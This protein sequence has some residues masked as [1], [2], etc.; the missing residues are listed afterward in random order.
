M[1]R[2][3][4]GRSGI[5]AVVLLTLLFCLI[6]AVY[7]SYSRAGFFDW[8][9]PSEKAKEAATVKPPSLPQTF[10]IKEI[11]PV[12]QG[13]VK[14]IFSENCD[15]KELGNLL[16]ILPP[17]KIWWDR[18][19]SIN[20]ETTIEGEFKAGQEYAV[21]LSDKAECKG[22]KYSK[23]I[24][25][26]RMPDLE[27]S[28]TFSEK[29]TVVERDGRQMV[30]AT[31]TNVDEL[32]FQGIRVPPLLV[33]WTIEEMKTSFS[34]E[35]FKDAV[36]KKYGPVKDLLGR[37]GEL[38]DFFA[39]IKY[40]SQ[41]FFPDKEHNKAVKIS[42]PLGFRE[43][44]E[45]GGIELISLKSGQN[46]R[47]A[48]PAVGLFRI[49]DLGISYKISED[50]LL[51]WITS[52]NTGLPV[53]EV[54]VL[55]FLKDS[56]IVPLGKTDENG[57]LLVKNNAVGNRI[58]LKEDKTDS[59]PVRIKDIIFVAA[60]SP[61]DS[62]F[63]ELKQKGTIKPD[64]ITQAKAPDEKIRLLKGHVFT[65]RGIYRPGEKVYFKGTVREYRDGKI[66]PPP[67]EKV[68]FTITDSKDEEVYGKE[69]ALSEFGT[70]NGFLETKAYFPLGTYTVNMQ[71]AK[72]TQQP[73]A[74]HREEFEGVYGEG[75]GPGRIKNKPANE[76]IATGTFEVQEFRAPRHFVEVSFKKEK[77]KDDSFV[78]LDMETEL[79]ICNISGSY[80]AGGP[81]KHGK[82]RWK[83]YF[84]NADF[85]KKEFPDFFFGAAEDGGK[86]LIESGES[87]LDE[88]GGLTVTLP[89]NKKISAGLHA[90]E[91]VATVLDFDGR[92]S[93]ETS[94]YQEEPEYM[95]GIGKHENNVKAGD[96]QIVKVIVTDKN[97]KK[98][99]NGSVD[100]SV[101]RKDYMYVRKRNED[102]SVYWDYKAVYRKQLSTAVKLENSIAVFDF[103]FVSGGDYVLQFSY[104]DKS[105]KE[106]SSSTAYDVYGYFYGYEYE[107]RELN[108]EKMSAASDKKEYSFG[109]TIKVYLNP[110]KKLSSILMTIEREGV[111]QYGTVNLSPGRKYIEIPVEKSFSPNIYISFLGIVPRGDFPSYTGQFDET[112]PGFLFGV[113][114]VEIKR[115]IDNLKL[116]VNKEDFKLKFEPGNE[117]T[118]RLSS[119]D[120][121]GKGVETEMA[122]CV[123]DESVLALTGFK[124]PSLEALLKFISPLSV[125][126]GELRSELLK[127]TPYRFIRNERLTG[128]DGGGM[129]ISASKLRKDFRPVAFFDP[130]VKT[131]ENGRA[132]VKFT[133]PDTM[134]T[135]RVYVVACDKGGRFAS[136]KRDLLVVKDFYLEPGTPRFFTK[137]DR[138]RFFVSAFNKTDRSG[139]GRFRLEK[140]ASVNIGTEDEYFRMKGF[141]GALLSVRG[142]AMKPGVSTLVFAGDFKDRKDIVEIK[143][144]VKSGFLSWNDVVFGTMKG[145]AKIAYKFPD[146]AGRIKWSELNP[147]EVKALLTISGS[148]FLRMSKAL[149][150]LLQYPYGCVEQTSSG[151]IPLAGLRGLIKD[152]LIAD[153]KSD[154]T[155]KFLN[156]GIERLLSMQTN[157][158]GFG[159]WPGD[160]RADMWGTIYAASAL[161]QAKLAGFEIPSDKINKAMQYLKKAVNEEGKNDASFRGFA[162]YILSMNGS[163][164]EAVFRDIYK[165]IKNMPREGALLLLLAAKKGGYAPEKELSEL[166]KTILEK[167]RDGKGYYSF[168]ARYREPAISLIA[169]SAI[170]KDD[171]LIGRL[172][173]ELLGG[174][175]KHGT[176]T[177][178]S[179]TGWSL[180]ALGEYYKGKSFAR[181]RIN[182]TI[183]QEG[184]PETNIVLDPKDSYNYPLEAV[185]FLKNPEVTIDSEGDSDLS[186]MLS[187]TFPRVDYAA[188]GYAKGFK[189]HKTIENT[190]GSSTIRTGDIV[191]VKIN[192]EAD[193][194][195]DYV[196]I[197]DPLPAGLV[198]INT[199]IKTEEK[200]GNDKQ[201]TD[202]DGYLD[203]WDYDGGF[204]RFTPNHFEMRD[205]R[206]LAFRNRL[207]RGNYQYSYYARAVCEG[208]FVMPSTKI[209]LMYEP[210]TASF[211]PVR[212]VSISGRE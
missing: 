132:E 59:V 3:T 96:S 207:W 67:S 127:Q 172:A 100:V 82:T 14:I 90:V 79:L 16:K 192:I 155:D 153:M 52:I 74:I 148:P 183:K 122:V 190:D 80:Y 61:A 144:P 13:S 44:R 138:F 83:I 108:F 125:F 92:A 129:D 171:I 142:E 130:V 7:P 12:K 62:S 186:Y 103:D 104:K 107:S 17:P 101:M 5:Q 69:A 24:S 162:S 203:Y 23:T 187:L 33:P 102:G 8:L 139:A 21:M 156:S 27:S 146:G 45:K 177:S 189:I 137:G 160:V 201:R 57:L 205:D 93:T 123:V 206:V 143:I 180:I 121:S 178:T 38:K 204:F 200:A 194:G 210:D 68:L 168:Y 163:L 191:K 145:S 81:V 48:V 94:V 37:Y 165:D 196:V 151:I 150:Y 199:A 46:S 111:L 89:L 99:E 159:Y 70:A 15:A 78:N 66:M 58:M 131:D 60:A 212:K 174:I 140:D 97:N 112:S 197:D 109:E 128:G 141:D 91:V 87:I 175:N 116:E 32:L 71:F 30:H 110:H 164:D 184:R 117:A 9:Y 4:S 50:S 43:E 105:G 55:A 198:A 26:F 166:A 157:D 18:S 170:L 22:N 179:D 20:N 35:K 51:I 73:Q 63:I 211:T 181:D 19:V 1:K 85:A 176:W 25:G 173:K 29:E 72:M 120:K 126:T 11:K 152:G 56:S 2:L 185:S 76:G 167:P 169:G 134:T 161:T 10:T 34:F 86:E 84:T 6:S 113:V 41:L 28:V 208:E 136:F 114:N 36:N 40:D 95:V 42:I 188:N 149:G 53:K 65:E 182:V 193:D 115:E 124:T 119:T 195:Y 54:S 98:V 147:D 133:L 77:K 39:D 118:L 64:W 49:T 158:G 154:E 202:E 88:K 209:Q 47:K 106:Y 135:Y 75:D 31:V